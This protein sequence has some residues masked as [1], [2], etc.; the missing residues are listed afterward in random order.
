MDNACIVA[1]TFVTDQI[2]AYYDGY[3]NE[4][5]IDRS[6]RRQFE[7]LVIAGYFD[8]AA[9][10]PY[11]SI[12]W[13]QVNTAQAQSLARQAAT[14]S[15]TLLKNDGMLPYSFAKGQ[16]VAMVGMWAN[17]TTQ[18]QGG[19]SG[20]A[21]YLHSP[22]YAAQ[23][24]GLD[25]A[26]ANGPLNDSTLFS[27]YS[28]PAMSAA[29]GADV[30]LY[31]GGIDIVVESEANDRYQIAWPQSQVALMQQ[32]A[33]LGKP[34]AVV[35][36]GT[37]LDATP[38]L[39]NENISSLLWAG[40]PGQDGGPA[41]FD[42][43]T[44][45]VAPAG[46]LPITMYPADYVNQVPMTN[47]SLRPGPNNP[48]R[49]YRWYND[50]VL[51]YAFGMHYTTFDAS[52][53]SGAASPPSYPGHPHGPP[54]W[55]PPSWGPPG[56]GGWGGPPASYVG[57]RSQYGSQPGQS[58]NIQQLLSDCNAPHPDLCPFPSVS[59]SVKNTGKTTSDYSAVV[60]Y[61]STAGPTPY[62]IKTSATYGRLYAIA[63]GQTSIISL[64]V[65]IGALARRDGNGDLTMYPGDYEFLLDVPTQARMPFSLTGNAV[66]LE[67]WPQPPVEQTYSAAEPCPLYGPCPE[68]GQ[69]VE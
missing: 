58:F 34:M 26:Y 20:P 61:N 10:N 9:S 4:S 50:A 49:T 44:G 3:V 30:I 41:V 43:L 32:L 46:R 31:F 65:T 60:F 23:Q 16:K 12:G 24:L 51:P 56:H 68:L 5:V 52:F 7:A 36:M 45:A 21:P 69:P 13:D 6:L 66:K 1:N 53:V 11:R 35:Q 64:N 2:G 17:G 54:G 8:P 59:V 19:Y 29:E 27:N 42:I 40:Y 38:V 39:N 25:C 22:L 55:N 14:E 48:G 62:P 63:P 33:A 15:I 18:M 28:G 67:A 57:W 47:M 37:M